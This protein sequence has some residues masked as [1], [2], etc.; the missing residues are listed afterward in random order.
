MMSIEQNKNTKYNMICSFTPEQQFK[1]S[2]D[3][4]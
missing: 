3:T 1:I 4:L 2:V